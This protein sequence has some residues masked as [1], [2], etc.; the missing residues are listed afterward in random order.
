[1]EYKVYELVDLEGQIV[2]VGYTSGSLEFRLRQHTKWKI[3]RWY[4]RTDLN[5]RTLLIH[6]TKKEA[7][8]AEG[9]RK[10]SLGMTWTEKEAKRKG[11]RL[12]GLN[13]NSQKTAKCPHCS[14]VGQ[15]LGM[16]Q[17]HFSNC[18]LN[19]LKSS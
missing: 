4:G 2:D 14:K 9:T 7:L 1:M 10:L 17:W 5:I 8:L 12:G 11:G 13:N 18:K 19:P 15:K 6:P 16:T 3:G